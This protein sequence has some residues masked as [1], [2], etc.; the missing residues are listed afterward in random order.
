MQQYEVD[1]ATGSASRGA[2]AGMVGAIATWCEFLHGRADFE[3]ALEEIVASLG[4]EAAVLSRV[5]RN[6][7]S[8]CRVLSFDTRKGY[9]RKTAISRC[10]AR[11]V[12]G[13]YIDKPKAGSIWFK[14]MMEDDID[15]ELVSL[16]RRR[17]LADLVV[18]P[19]GTAA[20]TTDFLEIHYSV[21]L[22]FEHRARLNTIAHTLA[23]TWKNRGAGLM[24]E[25]LTKV[26]LGLSS[27]Q[28]STP[29]L[30]ME[31]PARL[32]RAEYRVCLML[33][34]GNTVDAVQSELGI[35]QST[36]RTHL[37]NIYSKTGSSNQSELL[38]RLLSYTSPHGPQR[39]RQRLA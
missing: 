28:I 12:L 14:S 35:S 38:F 37:T 20:K 21:P 39:D 1:Q 34:R 24:T 10:F 32:S 5:P 8:R 13:S 17:N 27:Q 6:P 3:T 16:H 25:L 19:L 30:S 11:S 9:S 26:S 33:S 31:N 22:Q 36:L 29:I 2:E 15:P 4:A 18:V 7:D 23:R